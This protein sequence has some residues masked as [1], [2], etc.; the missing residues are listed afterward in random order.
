MANDR[1]D[2]NRIRLLT[3][4]LAEV[5]GRAHDGSQ[6][7]IVRA[8]GRVNLIGDHADY[9]EG[10]VLQA[11]IELDT[12]I[13][14]RRRADGMV[15][16]A[17]RNSLVTGSFWIDALAPERDGASRRAPRGSTGSAGPAGPASSLAT[18]ISDGPPGP[19]GNWSDYVAG[20]A[21]S[22]REAALP[23]RGFEGVVDTTIPIGSGLG[24]S[25]ALEL[26]S[27]LALLG[28][29]GPAGPSLAVM[30]QRAERDFVGVECGIVD[31][32]ASA[33]GR[34]GRALLID[35]R[36]LETGYA[37]LPYGVR[38]VICDTGERREP[39]SP[40][41][42]IRRAECARAVALLSEHIPGLCSMRDLDPTALRRRRRLLPENLARRAEHVVSENARV[43]ATMAALAAGDLEALGRLFA[44]SHA[45]MRDLFEVSSP[46]V[47]TMN[48]IAAT[49][50]GVVASRMTGVGYGGST[51][52]LVLADAV[53][54]L[55]AAVSREYDR[56]TGLRGRVYPV[57]VVDGAGPVTVP[58]P[59]A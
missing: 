13:A 26:A 37:P 45:S 55:Q 19:I 29:R 11:A 15:R 56:R 47:E 51:V 41:Q 36:S 46:A 2:Q 35:C 48:E 27:A 20:T 53:P 1:P 50:P 58:N 5:F 16:L 28:G 24:S 33:A 25:A 9:N 44:E 34:E 7:E 38:L 57:A 32:F 6:V 39:G 22:L 52:N 12:W 8:P 23:I 21:W 43:V 17:S 40:I 54:A 31:Q 14:F 30:A 18:D 59:E 4:E 49:I 3:T 42:A 10:L